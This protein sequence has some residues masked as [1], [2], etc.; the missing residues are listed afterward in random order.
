MKFIR[1]ADLDQLNT[2]ASDKLAIRA[3]PSRITIQLTAVVA[4]THFKTLAAG[5]R[6]GAGASFDGKTRTLTLELQSTSAMTPGKMAMGYGEAP[7]EGFWI[8]DRFYEVSAAAVEDV[9]SIYPN[10]NFA[11]LLK[12]ATKLKGG[13][14]QT[15]ESTKAD[16]AAR[17]EK[18]KAREAVRPEDMDM[19]EWDP[20]RREWYDLEIET[21]HGNTSGPG[22]EVTA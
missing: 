22:A 2:L 20:V 14:V 21:R 16:A 12:L 10:D 3:T 9:L 19:P 8:N 11:T 18:Q 13:K 1:Q 7:A 15:F 6:A 4:M 5:G 17:R